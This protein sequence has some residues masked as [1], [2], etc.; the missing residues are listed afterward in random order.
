[1][2]GQTALLQ[3]LERNTQPTNGTASVSTLGNSEV[4]V[5]RTTAT[6]NPGTWYHPGETQPMFITPASRQPIEDVFEHELLSGGV[7]QTMALEDNLMVREK[8]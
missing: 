4:L 3:M 2:W 1:M 8:N 5:P 7:T 6:H